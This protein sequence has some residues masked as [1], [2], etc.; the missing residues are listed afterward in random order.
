MKLIIPIV[1]I[2]I[3]FAS[4]KLNEKNSCH[5]FE[6]LN[7]KIILFINLEVVYGDEES[8]CSADK[9][10]QSNDSTGHSV[11]ISIQKDKSDKSMEEKS[12]DISYYD[13]KPGSIQDAILKLHNKD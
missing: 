8:F 13:A 5:S 11:N 9:T 3:L 10:C 12:S 2:C 4:G 6:L 7:F 1:F